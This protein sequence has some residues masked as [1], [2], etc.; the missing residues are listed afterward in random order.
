MAK[1]KMGFMRFGMRFMRF[2]VRNALNPSVFFN[3]IDGSMRNAL[4]L[5]PLVGFPL[6][7]ESQ[8]TIFQKG[9]V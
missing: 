1:P 5:N 6:V 9:V 7:F 3:G 2:S 8:N 4:A